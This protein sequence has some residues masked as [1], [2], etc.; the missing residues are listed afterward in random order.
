M[1]GQKI[2]P[3]LLRNLPVNRRNQVLGD[4]YYVNPHGAW[5]HLPRGFRGLT[6]DIVE[7]ACQYG[8][9]GYRKIAVLLRSTARWIV[10]DKRVER[11]WR[12]EGLKV[13]RNSLIPRTT[14]CQLVLSCHLGSI[15]FCARQQTRPAEHAGRKTVLQGRLSDLGAQGLQRDVGLRLSL[16]GLSKHTGRSLKKLDARPLD[17]VRMQV[18]FMRRF[19]QRF[20]TLDRSH[21]RFRLECKAMGPARTP[22]QGLHLAAA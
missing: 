16:G 8:R 15:F 19:D 13:Q 22:F 5:L 1:P 2:F 4:G 20:H 17:L 10:N 9:Y 7:I 12:R 18:E 11:I 14:T 21:R 6:A 3:Y